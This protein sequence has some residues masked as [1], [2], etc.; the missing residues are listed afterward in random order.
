MGRPLA[1]GL[2]LRQ[3]AAQTMCGSVTSLRTGDFSGETFSSGGDGSEGWC[4][5]VIEATGW[6]KYWYPSAE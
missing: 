1:T 5:S 3:V 2:V 6:K 4:K